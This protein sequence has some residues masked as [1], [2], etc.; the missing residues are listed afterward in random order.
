M[1]NCVILSKNKFNDYLFIEEKLKT[2]LKQQSE[3][4]FICIDG[5]QISEL[6]E[7]YAKSVGSTYILLPSSIDKE[8]LYIYIQSLPGKKGVIYFDNGCSTDVMTH[9]AICA[10]KNIP[11]RSFTKNF[12]FCPTCENFT[13]KP[14]DTWYKN[15]F[16][17]TNSFVC[18]RC[19]AITSN[20]ERPIGRIKDA[21][22]TENS[23]QLE[24]S[25][26]Q[27]QLC[28]TILSMAK[29]RNRNNY[30]LN[31]C[32]NDNNKYE[33]FLS[34]S[35]ENP[36]LSIHKVVDFSVD[37]THFPIRNLYFSA[38]YTLYVNNKT[39]RNEIFSIDTNGVCMNMS[40]FRQIGEEQPNFGFGMETYYVKSLVYKSMNECC[41]NC[42]NQ[43]N[44]KIEI[45]LSIKAKNGGDIG[46]ISVCEV[47]EFPS[48]T[49]TPIR[50]ISFKMNRLSSEINNEVF[51]FKKQSSNELANKHFQ[52]NNTLFEQAYT[53]REEMMRIKR[54]ELLVASVPDE[55]YFS[56]SFEDL[57]ARCQEASEIEKEAYYE[58]MCEQFM[59][60][61]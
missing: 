52:I 61:E 46:V 37:A 32:G 31:C 36:K 18:E 4:A 30:I 22:S 59:L 57:I 11:F 53:T 7:Y 19:G 26:E 13:L 23:A 1:F 14:K 17:L 34:D 21:S 58:K 12:L 29:E 24:D 49:H 27:W 35:C 56:E 16:E 9:K 25:N 33:V 60:E 38:N 45:T 47:E 51:V 40:L 48:A 2:M 5:E 28:F 43:D 44:E 39:L 55:H 54:Q 6:V 10:K 15:G 41:I 3:V 42:Y 50:P 8:K 20:G